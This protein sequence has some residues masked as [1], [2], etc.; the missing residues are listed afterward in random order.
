M[1]VKQA[2]LVEF[3]KVQKLTKFQK[4]ALARG[5][6]K[7]EKG[8]E[9]EKRTRQFAVQIIELSNK[10]PIEFQ[11]IQKLPKFQKLFWTQKG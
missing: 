3:Q 7:K 10:L 8:K 11:K 2:G 4:L 6:N 1:G 9:L 5:K